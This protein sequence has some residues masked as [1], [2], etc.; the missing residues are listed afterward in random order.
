MD[1]RHFRSRTSSSKDVGRANALARGGL[2]ARST[3]FSG[4]ASKLDEQCSWTSRSVSSESK[5]NLSYTKRN[6][7]SFDNLI[8]LLS[9]LLPLHQLLSPITVCWCQCSHFGLF[10]S[11]LLAH[12]SLSECSAV[13][14]PTWFLCQAFVWCEVTCRLWV[15]WIFWKML[16]HFFG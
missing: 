2:S 5:A 10:L 4:S 12:L 9:V 13:W 8:R 15:K 6:P 11:V 16:H 7:L 3:T 1:C 14:L